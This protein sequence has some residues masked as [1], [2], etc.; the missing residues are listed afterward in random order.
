MT[1][2]ERLERLEREVA[3]LRDRLLGVA[4]YCARVLGRKPEP[5]P[6]EPVGRKKR[7]SDD[8]THTKPISYCF[9]G[10]QHRVSAFKDILLG[11]CDTL[12]DEHGADFERVLG[13]RGFSRNPRDLGKTSNPRETARSGI[14]VATNRSANDLMAQCRKVLDLFGHSEDEVTVE[15][16]DPRTR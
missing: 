15:V 8:F 5:P 7:L 3:D 6:P 4:E 1:T 13:L 9:L 16:R 10:Q 11:L 12:H 2:Q 14:H